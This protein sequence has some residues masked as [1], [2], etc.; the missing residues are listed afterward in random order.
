M[1][2]HRISNGG[3]IREKEKLKPGDMSKSIKNGKLAWIPLVYK[4]TN[5]EPIF[6][7]NFDAAVHY[8][9]VRTAVAQ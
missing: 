3:L 7:P 8:D 1:K 4:F 9:I 6:E 5:F 2:A